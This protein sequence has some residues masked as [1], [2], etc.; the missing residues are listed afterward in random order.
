MTSRRPATGE[1]RGTPAGSWRPGGAKSS[2]STRPTAACRSAPSSPRP[3]FTI[4]RPPS[5]WAT[6]TVGRVVNLYDLM[7][8]AYDAREIHAISERLGH[9]PIIDTNP[10]RDKA[11]KEARKREAR[12]PARRPTCRG[13][14]RPIPH[15]H[16]RR[17]DQRPSQGRVRRP[18][19][20]R[21]RSHKIG[22]LPLTVDRVI[23]LAAP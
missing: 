13:P 23:R 15:P 19:R 10:R 7:D 4:P 3:P 20:P 11:L 9:V 14:N 22:L 1:R 5:P 16:R 17:E 21:A 8:A 18:P 6:M 12:A 2:T